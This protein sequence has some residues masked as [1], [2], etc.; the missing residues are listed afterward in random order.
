MKQKEWA[1]QLIDK[2]LEWKRT[3]SIL[4]ASEICRKLADFVQQKGDEE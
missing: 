2:V 4:T 1:K 3:R